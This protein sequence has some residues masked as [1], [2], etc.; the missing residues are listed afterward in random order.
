MTA[1]IAK[2]ERLHKTK[3]GKYGIVIDESYYQL[4]MGKRLFVYTIKSIF[5]LQEHQICSDCKRDMY[6]PISGE[7]TEDCMCRYPEGDCLSNHLADADGE[8]GCEYC[9]DAVRD[10]AD[11]LRKE[12]QEK[13][14]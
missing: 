7:C 1:Q 14:N 4:I 9:I 13:G 6:H 11:S 2:Y 10:H 5:G 8:C 3:L 12:A